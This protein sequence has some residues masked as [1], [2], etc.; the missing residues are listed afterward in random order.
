MQQTYYFQDVIEKLRNFWKNQS[1]VEVCGTNT[2]VGA[3]TLN[4]MTAMQTLQKDKWN[5]C[6][7]QQ[8]VRP[9]DGRFGQN[10]NRLFQHHQF[11]VIMKPSPKKIKDL[12]L[13]SLDFLQIDM[14][15]NEIKFLEDDWQNP[16]I[17]AKGV[18]WEVWCN[19]IEISQFTYINQIG[20]LKCAEIA[21]EITYGLE[22]L[23]LF[24]QNKNDVFELDWNENI[25][26]KDLF[27]QNE[28]DFSNFTHNNVDSAIF[29]QHFDDYEQICQQ[30]IKKNSPL[31][32]YDFCLKCIH[33]LNLLDAA[34]KISYQERIN[35]IARTRKMARDCSELMIS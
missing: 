10:K 17:G 1:C 11:Q 16:S 29:L 28:Q 24:I 15:N 4:S 33:N 21:A 20:S 9:Q 13:Q 34:Q 30:L 31:A 23:M 6:Y 14:Q 3:G 8:S 35:F 25:K 22:R 12:Y 26:Y 5:V 18:G 32:A 2:E 19:G 27:L 7:V